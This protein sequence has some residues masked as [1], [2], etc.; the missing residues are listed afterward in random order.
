MQAV[1]KYGRG[2]KEIELRDVPEPPIGPADALVAVHAAGI[3]GSDIEQWHDGVPWPINV[4]VICGHEFCGRVVAVGDQVTAF[5]TGHRVVSETAAVICGRCP[6]CRSGHYNLCPSRLG[7]GYGTDGAFTRLV[8]VPERCLHHVPA[9]VPDEY[10][11]LAEPLSVAYSAVVT[12]ARVRPGEPLVVIGPG[13]I[14]LFCVQMARVSGATP[15]YAVGTPA[16]DRRLGTALAVGADHRLDAA[17]AAEAILAATGRWGV[18]TVIDAAGNSAAEQLALTVAARDGEIVKLGWG[19]R[20]LEV[21]YDP[22]VQKAVTLAGSFSHTWRSWEAVLALLAAGR[23]D[24][25]AMVTHQ[26]ALSD[27]LPAFE[28]MERQEAVKVVL[29]PA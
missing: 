11:C 4:P 20:P 27:W 21:D 13:P 24:M 22:L 9:S 6:A 1:V 14:G 10:A 16:D 26:F 18:P 8:K 2:F 29:H 15:I 17:E 19:R 28:T 23:I 5:A 25:A 3:C 7:F 12:R